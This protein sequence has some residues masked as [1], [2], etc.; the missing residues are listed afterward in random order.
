MAKYM[1]K[2]WKDNLIL[3][4]LL[5]GSAGSQTIASVI[6]A[7]AMNALI[8]LDFQGFFETSLKMFVIFMFLLV[9]T[10]LRIVKQT[11]TIQKMVTSIREDITL[12]M[13]KTSYNSF[14][15]K[16]VGTYASWLSNDINT[17]ETE[18][19]TALY[20]VLSGII[21]TITSVIGLL[22]FHWS[23]VVWSLVATGITLL[24]PKI[25]E[26]KMGE[27]ALKTTQENERF[28]SKA[29]DVLGGFDT[30]FSYSLLKKIT[31]D[32]KE[33]SLSLADSKLNQSRVVGRVAILGTFGNIFGH[34][35]ILVL[36]CFVSRP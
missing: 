14:H 25:Y 12:R 21:A 18:S 13:E 2:F 33:A 3:C 35:S 22:F 32:I 23:L 10:Y 34:L 9:F 27:A 31:T 19:F 29:N 11:K 16:Q 8:E 24:L 1:K 26:K 20:T 15:E 36:P 7:N 28:L 6:N 5:L 4:L 17:I 30:L